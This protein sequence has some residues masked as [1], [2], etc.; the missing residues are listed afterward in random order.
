MKLYYVYLLRDQNK[1]IYIGYTE[2]LERRFCEHSAKK[3]YYTKRLNNPQI[4][5]FEAYVDEIMAKERERKLKQY[6]S[7]YM[8][9]MKRIGL[10]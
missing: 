7:A 6:G 8:G 9:L 1:K 5:Y 3:V 4:Y 2:N 10:K